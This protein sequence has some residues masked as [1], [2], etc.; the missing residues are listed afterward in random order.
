MD[1]IPL[2]ATTDSAKFMFDLISRNEI[3]AS[4]SGIWLTSLSFVN[5][6]NAETIAVFTVS[7]VIAF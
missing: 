3:S 2:V 6:P 4:E 5:E 1:A 7:F